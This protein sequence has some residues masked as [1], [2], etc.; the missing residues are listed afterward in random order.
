M[1]IQFKTLR[2]IRQAWHHAKRAGVPVSSLA[3]LPGTVLDRV[4]VEN[5]TLV[6]NSTGVGFQPELKLNRDLQAAAGTG[7]KRAAIPCPTWGREMRNAKGYGPE[8]KTGPKSIPKT[9]MGEARLVLL[10]TTD[11]RAGMDNRV[12][13]MPYQRLTSKI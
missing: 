10:A 1:T 5:S 4:K 8:S 6:E 2:D 11:N 3:D 9:P 13:V 12:K 7:W